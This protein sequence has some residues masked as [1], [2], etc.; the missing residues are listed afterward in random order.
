MPLDPYHLTPNASINRVKMSA[1]SGLPPAWKGRMAYSLLG[2]EFL[3][4]RI[5]QSFS[6]LATLPDPVPVFEQQALAGGDEQA[7]TIVRDYGA[8][9]GYLLLTL[10]TGAPADRELR[11]EW[12]ESYWQHWGSRQHIIFGGGMM[13]G[14]F[15]QLALDAVRDIVGDLLTVEISPLAPILPLIGLARRLPPI[16]TQALVFDFGGTTV[17]RACVTIE[18]ARLTRVE[19]LP[20]T[21]LPTL[22]DGAALLDFMIATISDTWRVYPSPYLSPIISLSLANY[23]EDQRPVPDNGYGRLL[24]LGDD[25]SRLLDNALA[26]ET[27][28]TVHIKLMH[29]GT[30]AGLAYADAVNTA[31]IMVGTALGMG[32]PPPDEGLLG[33]EL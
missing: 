29:D 8:A 26:H 10:K 3:V 22:P 14:L 6:E 21:A 15:G 33:L 4:Q 13:A 16:P 27:G 17:K 12:D 30:A 9:L 1:A 20:S 11:P 2:R 24:E 5:H 32:F 23:V 7:V 28:Q 31:V 19:Q 18:E 25:T